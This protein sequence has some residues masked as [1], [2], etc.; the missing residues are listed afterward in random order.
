MVRKIQNSTEYTQYR[1]YRR[2][3]KRLPQSRKQRIPWERIA[4][5]LLIALVAGSCVHALLVGCGWLKLA[6]MFALVTLALVVFAMERN[7]T[8]S[9]GFTLPGGISL[10]TKVKPRPSDADH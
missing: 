1:S 7:A 8:L 3:A 6:S 4:C 5:W 9:Y 2:N 10:E